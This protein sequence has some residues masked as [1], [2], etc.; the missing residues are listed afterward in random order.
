MTSIER[1]ININ[2]PLEVV[3]KYASDYRTWGEWFEG[4]SDFIPTTESTKGNGTRYAYKAKMMGLEVKVET[5]IYNYIENKG[6]QGKSTTGMPHQTLWK[7][8]SIDKGTKFTY[9]LEYKVPLPLIGNLIDK[10]FLLPKWIRII[11]KSLQNLDQK[12]KL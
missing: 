10:Y 12:F 7:F 8:E 6:W 1:S 3:F 2:Q 9:G 11:E 5:E 4:V